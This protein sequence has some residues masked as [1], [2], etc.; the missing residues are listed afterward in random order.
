LKLDGSTTLTNRTNGTAEDA[1]AQIDKQGYLIP[2]T[3]DRRRLVKI[4]VELSIVE[5]GIQR[6]LWVEQNP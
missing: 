2:Y 1:L 6:W 3:A 4:G 5:R